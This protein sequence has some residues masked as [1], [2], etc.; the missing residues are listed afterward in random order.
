MFVIKLAS[1]TTRL[2]LL[3]LL[4]LLLP[5]CG[6]GNEQSRKSA[7]HPVEVATVSA[8]EEGQ[9]SVFTAVL[10]AWRTVRVIAQEEGQLVE[11][12]VYEGD[13]VKQGQVIARL[14]DSLL[15]AELNK[16]IATRRQAQKDLARLQTLK[17]KQLV[18]DEQLS[19]AQ[20]ALAVA[21][22]DEQA[23]RTRV[24]YMAIRAPFDGVIS[25]RLVEPGDVIARHQ[26][27]LTLLD[28]SQLRARLQVSELF[29]P[30][31]KKDDPAQVRIDALGAQQYPAQISRIYPSVDEQTRQGVV[32]ILL[33]NV[34]EGA[35]PG[36]LCRVQIQLP[37]TGR[38]TIPLIAIRHDG[39]ELYVYRVNGEGKAQR[40]TVRIGVHLGER[41]EIIEGLGL[42]EQ[43]ITR[44]FIGLREGS[45]VKVVNGEREGR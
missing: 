30:L 13:R 39:A 5:A 12:P 9:S 23:L 37:A 21:R 24:D 14:D 43:V 8:A 22:A 28:D 40:V 33:K 19:R 16:T 20:T 34:P 15:R 6:D 3:L 10:E 25:Q 44:G 7:G 27:I 32:E 42:G 18:S 4:S 11:L 1:M 31:M 29:L 38:A 2:T 36:Q 35:L 26:H 17:K 45:P 41:V